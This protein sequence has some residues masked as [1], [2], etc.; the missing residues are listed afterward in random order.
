MA[1]VSKSLAAPEQ[2]YP[3]REHR[4]KKGRK[5]NHFIDRK[6]RIKFQRLEE[7]RKAW[8]AEREI[9]GGRRRKGKW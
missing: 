4:S 6:R 3:H 7:K 8:L 5:E 9:V 1:R 2:G